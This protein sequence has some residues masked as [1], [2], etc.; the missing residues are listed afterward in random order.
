MIGSL[1]S[2]IG[3]LELGLEWAGLG[4][5]AWQVEKD[6]YARAVLAKHWP[7]A[8]RHEDVRSVGA[9]NLQ[10]VDVLCGGFPCQDL[11]YA[12]RGAGLEGARSGLWREYARVVREL[13]P[14]V[15]IVENVPALRSRGLGRV[16]GDLA[17]CG[18]DAVWTSL[19]ASDVGAPHKRERL[20]VVG[21]SAQQRREGP[22]TVRARQ[23]ESAHA[24]ALERADGDGRAPRGLPRRAQAEQPEP[25]SADNMVDSISERCEG[26]D[27]RG[28][29]A[30]PARRS[31]TVADAYGAREHER[32]EGRHSTRNGS[33][34]SS[35]RQWSRS[36]E[37]RVVRDAHGLPA[38]LDGTVWPAGRGAEQ[39]PQE[40]PRTGYGIQW[41]VDRV[42]CLGNAVVPQVAY[43]IGRIARELMEASDAR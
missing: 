9:H 10:R 40:P 38:G 4:P 8:V 21:Y 42:R 7:N 26:H 13:R 16:L 29:D 41:R 31:E 5:V 11:S 17:E 12:G 22:D 27:G 43:V 18:Y 1:F 20:F 2:G 24:S 35:E 19:A 3:G 25:G 28:S 23:P 34:N 15:V 30:K 32:A 37:S 33:A 14:R 39:K 6:E 36:S